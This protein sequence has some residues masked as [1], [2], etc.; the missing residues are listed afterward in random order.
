M[1]IMTTLEFRK[2]SLEVFECRH[3]EAEA[4]SSDKAATLERGYQAFLGSGNLQV[5]QPQVKEMDK[6]HQQWIADLEIFGGVLRTQG[7]EP[8]TQEAVNEM[9]QR[10]AERIKILAN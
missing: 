3:C 9:F 10:L 8:K 7:A 6:L 1:N 4:R 2:T 5:F